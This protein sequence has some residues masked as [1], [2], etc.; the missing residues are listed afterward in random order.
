MDS[1]EPMA[2][3]VMFT[4]EAAEATAMNG[5]SRIWRVTDDRDEAERISMGAM[6]VVPLVREAADEN[7]DKGIVKLLRQVGELIDQTD[8]WKGEKCI[9][10]I[11]TPEARMARQAYWELWKRFAGGERNNKP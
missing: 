11:V 7:T 5:G 2:W 9:A 1:G 10:A 8:R 4:K 3:A 6:E